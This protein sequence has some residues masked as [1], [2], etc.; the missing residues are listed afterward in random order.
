M[1]RCEFIIDLGVELATS[2]VALLSSRTSK[3]PH[4]AAEPCDG[5]QRP[6]G[7]EKREYPYG[8]P[9]DPYGTPED[10]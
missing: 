2:L 8:T 3:V 1:G 7:C 9:E 6:I 4:L 5:W 10:P